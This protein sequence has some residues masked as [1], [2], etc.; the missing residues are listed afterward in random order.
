MK[1]GQGLPQ[2]S[3][4]TATPESDAVAAS[5]PAASRRSSGVLAQR[6]CAKRP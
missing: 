2:T 1:A 6:A 3:L 4:M 5:R